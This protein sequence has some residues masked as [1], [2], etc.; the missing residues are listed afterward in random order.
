MNKFSGI[1]IGIIL[2]SISIVVMIYSS[3]N[4][5][6]LK[7]VGVRTEGEVYLVVPKSQP[8][9]R[10]IPATYNSPLISFFTPDGKRHETVGCDDC[11]KLGDKVPVIYDPDNPEHAEVYSSSLNESYYYLAGFIFFLLLFIRTKVKLNKQYK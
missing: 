8:F 2:L 3:L 5:I 11:Y 7:A 1:N 6:K 9:I 4:N 10:H